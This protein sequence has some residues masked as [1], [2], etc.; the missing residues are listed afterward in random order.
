MIVYSVNRYALRRESLLAL[1]LITCF[2][3]CLVLR[4]G[5]FD[6]SGIVDPL[7]QVGITGIGALLALPLFLPDAQHTERHPTHLLK[8]LALPKTSQQW[9]PLLLFFSILCHAIG[10]S[11]LL[12]RISRHL[13]IPFP[14]WSD[15]ACL[16]AVLP[17]LLAILLLPSQP[18]PTEKRLHIVLDGLMIMVGAITFSWYFILGPSISQGAASITAQIVSLAYPLHVLFLVFCLLLLVLRTNDQV[19]RPVV[20]L[21]SLGL[22]TLTVSYS[23]FGYE[24]LHHLFH[25]AEL[26]EV[27]WV[28]GYL[29]FGLAARAMQVSMR[30]TDLDIAAPSVLSF[31]PQSVEHG[32]ASSWLWRP[33]LPYLLVTP[34]VLLLLGFSSFEGNHT[35]EPGVYLGALALG[36]LLVVRQIFTIR[37]M[38]AQN[39]ALCLMQQDLQQSNKALRLVNGQLEERTRQLEQANEQLSHL[40]RLRNQF[41][42]NVN[43]ELRT[44]LTQ[45]D[46]YL[47]LLS[48]YQG[49]L[50]ETMQATFIKRAKEGSQE[51]LVLVDNILDTL[52]ITNEIEPAPLESVTL[53]E[54]VHEVCGHFPPQGEQG[55]RLHVE[56][57]A[58]LVVKADQRYLQQILRNLL[59]NALKYSPSETSVT[60]GAQIVDHAGVSQ[61]C[62][63]VQDA[64]PGIPPQQQALLF[65]KF[66]R[67]KRDL[68]GPVRGTGLGLY[69][70]KQLVEVMHGEIW[71]ESSGKQG[72]GSCFCFTLETPVLRADTSLHDA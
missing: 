23:I 36:G 5:D 63:R 19:A 42:A 64:G 32:L 53:W 21:L 30:S 26:L 66:V 54:V 47:D 18:L 52:R 22:V 65:Q 33:L 20:L 69:I 70:C 38:I 57:P 27:G 35:L 1:V 56:L 44:P 29:L 68:L 31:S 2:G 14:Y 67:L 49:S 50:D 60:I 61:V 39:I 16:S 34:L 10:Q 41:I 71:V 37:A 58:S 43:H 13:A 72:E 11:I 9:V 28:L 46:G 40:H 4:P 8:I 45:I 6:V 24:R 55:S 48:E 17:L 3:C 59:S 7:L 25:P 15:V 12:Y 51:L 62:V